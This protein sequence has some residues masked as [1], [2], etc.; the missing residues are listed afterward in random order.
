MLNKFPLWKNLLILC[1]VSFGFIYSAPNFY[2][3]D[4]AVQISG[5]SGS[6]VIDESVLAKVES[7]LN[8]ANIEHF[9]GEAD[10]ESALVRITDKK[11]QLRAKDV[12]Q[13]EMGGDYIVALNLAPTT[14]EWLSSLGGTP[15][16]LGLDLSGGVHFLLEVDLDSAVI[17]R[18]E[19]DL[20]DIKASLREERVRYRS[21]DLK[22]TQIVGQFRDIEQVTKAKSII[23]TNYRDLQIQSIPG[24]NPLSMVL[25]LS[26]VASSLLEDNALK[27][28][29]T[30]LR[31]RVNELGVSEP[32][33]SRQGK[34]RI[35]VE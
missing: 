27:Q 25:N 28:N 1:V 29:L 31:N 24:Q 20:Q 34:N 21:F 10:G 5:Q 7:A 17:V 32:L 15:M 19:G 9:Y 4:A 18:L 33:V 12:I 2:P 22:G 8:E 6:M 13:A 14:P 16:K 30:S 11:L 26:D 3:A 23:R 35:V